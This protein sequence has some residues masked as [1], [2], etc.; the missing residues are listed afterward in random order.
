M[1]V[2]DWLIYYISIMI[3]MC[4]DNIF[5]IPTSPEYVKIQNKQYPVRVEG[6]SYNSLID[7][8][9]R[10]RIFS[11]IKH[12]RDIIPAIISSLIL[13]LVSGALS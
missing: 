11:V 9:I 13:A 5:W 2:I 6:K 4:I 8:V 10:Y 1:F 3:A 12:P 7:Y